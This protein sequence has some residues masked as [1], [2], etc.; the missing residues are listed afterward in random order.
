MDYGSATEIFILL[1]VLA[2]VC[3]L[4][5]LSG[6]F[7]AKF[8]LI[9]ILGF[10]LIIRSGHLIDLVSFLFS[11][12]AINFACAYLIDTA[13]QPK[14]K[15]RALW[16]GLAANLAWL[17]WFKYAGGLTPFIVS[18][19][20][21]GPGPIQPGHFPVGLSFYTLSQCMY[22]IDLFQGGSKR[23]ALQEHALCASFF[24]SFS[25][26]PIFRYAKV[27]QA[28]QAMATAGGAAIAGRVSR[29]LYLVSI[30][31]AK[32]LVFSG[33]FAQFANACFSNAAQLS[34]LE[35]AIGAAA[36]SLQLYFDF[37]GYSDIARGVARMIGFELPNNFNSPFKAASVTEFWT[38]WHISLSQFI[39]SYLFTPLMRQLGTVTPHKAAFATLVVMTIAGAWH[40]SG[41]NFLLFGL[42]HGSAMG[43]LYY[44]RKRKIRINRFL[45]QALTFVFVIFAFMVFRAES[46]SNLS[47]L[48]AALMGRQSLFGL[49]VLRDNILQ[50]REFIILAPV[51]LLGILIVFLC[52]N[53]NQ[54]CERARLNL[55]SS[56]YCVQLLFISFI[57]MNS[58]FLPSFIYKDF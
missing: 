43:F 35:V 49:N 38:R 20:Q 5:D 2:L 27:L 29:G 54:L 24:P 18:G 30:G 28:A 13:S 37:S 41:L 44:W 42:L 21:P 52:P 58:L 8:W 57:F 53:S 10:A 33:P 40:G 47:D 36:F 26:G 56:F 17:C 31:L 14:Q 51:V 11:M 3:I 16:V 7:K 25:A 32:K 23:L 22:L 55:R 6:Q 39:T 34:A 4:L 9:P 12:L 46:L 19:L 1:P 48:M 45:A 15:Q 50:A